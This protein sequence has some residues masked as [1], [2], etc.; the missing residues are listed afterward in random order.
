[1]HNQCFTLEC[2]TQHH[3]FHFITQ[4]KNNKNECLCAKKATKLGKFTL[5]QK[6]HKTRLIKKK[7]RASITNER[8]SEGGLLTTQHSRHLEKKQ[9][10][11]SPHHNAEMGLANEIPGSEKPGK[12][13]KTLGSAAHGRAEVCLGEESPGSA[14]K[15]PAV[16]QEKTEKIN[17]KCN[18]KTD[19]RDCNSGFDHRF[20]GVEGVGGGICV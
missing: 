19:P 11:L 20:S 9:W 13:P 18:R 15:P 5:S 10:F 6:S 1:M 3:S 4:C 16:P 7:S 2:T 14:G 8:H 12:S 17:N